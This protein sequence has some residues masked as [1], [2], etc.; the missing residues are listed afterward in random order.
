MTKKDL[1]KIATQKALED[2][3]DKQAIKTRKENY[4]QLIKTIRKDES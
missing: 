4:K 1:K 3:K 2:K